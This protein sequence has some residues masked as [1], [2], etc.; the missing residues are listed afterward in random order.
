M[1]MQRSPISTK[2]RSEISANSLARGLGWFSIGLGVAEL[3]M[4]RSALRPT[5]IPGKTYGLREIVNG[6][7]VLAAK[8]PTPW[9][10]ARVGGDVM[11]LATIAT[12]GKGPIA[13]TALV[14]VAGA[15]ALDVIC[16]QKLKQKKSG[17]QGS[18]RDY[19]ARSGFAR[20]AE[21]MRGAAKRPLKPGADGTQ[22]VMEPQEV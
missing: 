6:V 21:Q 11:D 14:A 15:T 3:L 16:A 5:G 20:P 12:R 2:Y 18:I 10:W 4:S 7:G 13:V 1:D 8:D 9:I 19:S 17:A 22:G